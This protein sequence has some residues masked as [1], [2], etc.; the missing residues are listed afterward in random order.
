[1]N[2]V[3]VPKLLEK[4]SS[5]EPITM[6]TAYDYTFAKIADEAGIDVMLVGDSLGMVVLGHSTTLPV[7]MEDMI[8]HTQAVARGTQTALVVAD[9]PFMSYQA[10][11]EDAVRNAGRLIRDGL[12]HAV[13]VEGGKSTCAAI[14]RIIAAGM[15]VMGHL[16]LTPQSIHVLGG[17]KVQGKSKDESAR[18][19]EDAEALQEA[20]C[21]SIVLECVPSSLASEISKRLTI[22]VIG[23]GAGPDCDGQVLV[24]YDCLG[25]TTDLKPK[26]V[27]RFANLREETSKAIHQYI[28]EVKKKI[29]PSAEQ[30]F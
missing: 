2:K 25:L 1:M 7:S 14:R 29:F 13:K 9:M 4:K 23:I 3:T 6:I 15:P 30:S 11:E 19:L 16:G 28:H 26:F 18:L 8:R 5:H 12:A 10:S 21:F 17:Y 27:K 20:G 22:P 24:L